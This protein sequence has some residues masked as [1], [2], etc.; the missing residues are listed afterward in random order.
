MVELLHA[1]LVASQEL[2]SKAFRWREEDLRW[3]GVMLL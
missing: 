1:L 2:S 3:R